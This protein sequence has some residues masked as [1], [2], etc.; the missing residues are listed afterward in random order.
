MDENEFVAAAEEVLDQVEQIL[1]KAADQAGVDIDIEVMPDG[2]LKLEFDNGS[3]MI[4]NRHVAARE[5]WV[6]ARSGGFHF[7]SEAGRWVGTRDGREFWEAL[8][9]MVSEQAET[10]LSL[11]A[12]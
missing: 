3:Q 8:S 5:I 9:A 4:I 6:A 2:V 11:R 1:E 7:R 12:A 10:S